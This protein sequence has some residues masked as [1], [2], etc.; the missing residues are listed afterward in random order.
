MVAGH[1]RNRHMARPPK[2]A[3][4]EHRRRSHQDDEPDDVDDFDHWVKPE[5]LPHGT[6]QACAFK[7]HQP[8]RSD[9]LMHQRNSTVLPSMVMRSARISSG[10]LRL[11]YPTTVAVVPAVSMSRAIPLRSIRDGGA[12]TTNQ[13]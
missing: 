4:V 7:P 2:Q 10:S 12:S 11:G 9:R 1:I 3:D 6:G 5:P 13:V 8:C